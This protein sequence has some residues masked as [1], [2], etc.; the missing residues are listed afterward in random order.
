MKYYR[1]PVQLE[2]EA[3][4]A[5]EAYELATAVVQESSAPGYDPEAPHFALILPET[6]DGVIAVTVVER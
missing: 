6:V 2:F 5:Q 3:D 1:V 4:S